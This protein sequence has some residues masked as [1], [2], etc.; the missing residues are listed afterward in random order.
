MIIKF[1][2]SKRENKKADLVQQLVSRSSKQKNEIIHI[3]H[4]LAEV[5]WSYLTSATIV[6]PMWN[7]MFSDYWLTY[8]VSDI[9]P[10]VD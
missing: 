8:Q 2:H 6:L 10:D 5:N 9:L 3:G 7:V 1:C 4:I